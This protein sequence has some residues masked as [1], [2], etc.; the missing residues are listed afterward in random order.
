MEWSNIEFLL[1]S[2]LSRLLLIPSFLG[3]TY[4]DRISVVKIQDA[5]NEAIE[6][7]RG[8]Y[9]FGVI[10]ES[11]L[12][13]IEEVNESINR[14]RGSRNRFAHFCWSR[15]TDD[16]IFGT[17]F[18]GGLPETKK[19]RKGSKLLTSQELDILYRESYSIVEELSEIVQ[20]LPELDEKTIARIAKA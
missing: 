9:G 11:K 14:V 5:I 2:I 15:F 6:L 10:E 7:H 17:N 8:R 1:K 3:R 20:S 16:S 4:T 13:R 19:G 18:S 12:K